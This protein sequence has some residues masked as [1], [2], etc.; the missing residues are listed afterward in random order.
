MVKLSMEDKK[1]IGWGQLLLLLFM[2]RVFT[3]M[4]FVPFAGSDETLTVHITAAAIGAVIQGI[5]LIPVV[6]LKGSVTGL[7]LQKNKPAGIILTALYLVFFLFY[8]SGSLIDF[9]G[10]LN[11]KFFP[12]AD[13]VLWIG[14]LLIVGVYCGCLGIEALGRSAVLLF[15]IFIAS[16][17]IMCI[18]SVHE[19]DTANLNFGFT[20]AEGLFSAVLEDLSR[21]GEICAL[22]FLAGNVRERLR[23][24]VYG[25]LVSKLVLISSATLLITA[26]LGDFAS[27]TQ[28]P[29]LAVGAFGDARFIERGDALY[30]IVWTITAIINIA[31]F[32]HISAG[33]I[34][35]VFPKCRFR[36]TIS[37]VV[38]FAMTTCFTLTGLSFPQVYDIV[39]SGWSIVLLAGVIPLIVLISQIAKK[40]GGKRSDA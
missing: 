27:L 35:E 1:M 33:L 40:K 12:T 39:C 4:T 9:R 26:V 30:L 21:N 29:F 22:A 15:W 19:F 37:A 2:C 23:C 20:S 3:L 34:G 8:T 32:L 16:L 6:I 36:T 7:T 31:L 5:L 14:V 25:L 17:V 24:G 38:V 28:Y 10:F 18:S 13:S 11:A